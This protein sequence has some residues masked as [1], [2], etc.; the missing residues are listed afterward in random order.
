MLNGADLEWELRVE[1]WAECVMNLTYLSNIISTKS[2]SKRSFELLYG[3]KP[4]LNHNLKISGVVGVVRTKEK[5]QAKLRNRGTTC[6]FVG[7]TEHYPRDDYRI[8]NLT[9]KS[10]INSKIYWYA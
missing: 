9:T 7:Y 3:E 4:I 6:M 2:S 8:L 10:I 5:I 1:I